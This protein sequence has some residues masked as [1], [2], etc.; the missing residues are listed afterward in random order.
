MFDLGSI[1][2]FLAEIF[3]GAKNVGPGVGKV[4][5]T[6]S[7][8]P[9]AEEKPKETKPAERVFETEKYKNP[10]VEPRFKVA[11]P[12]AELSNLIWE[13]FPNDATR[14]AAV[15]G[16]EVPWYNLRQVSPP[17]KN[18]SF[19]VGAYQINSDTLADFMSR[20]PNTMKKMGVTSIEDMKDPRKNIQ[21]AKLLQ[22]E[23]GWGAWHAP[24]RWGYDLLGGE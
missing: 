3:A 22:G 16:T 19:D 6:E 10:N 5:A 15:A 17:N 21:M 14:A 12:P 2:K 13:F 23:Q 4:G 7:A 9:K 18:G 1:L 20:Y 8:I 24:K 11:T